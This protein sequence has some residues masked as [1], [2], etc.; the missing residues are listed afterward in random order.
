MG[1]RATWDALADAETR[2][3]VGDP[4]RGAPELAALFGRLG[5]DPRGGVC[6]EVGCGP[7]RMTAELAERFDRVV[8]L[9]ISPAMIERAR[10]SIEATNVEFR[11]ISGLRLDGVDD[12]VADAVVCYLVLQ[13]LPRRRLVESFVRE[14]ARVLKASGE[15][16]VQLPVLERGARPRAWRL[17]RTVSVPLLYRLLPDP[18]RSPA[19]RGVRLT[20]PELARTLARANLKVC[21]RDEGPDAPYRFSRDVFL[22]LARG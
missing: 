9:D 13:H 6:V 2:V 4:T 7:G 8:A 1:M 19:L 22:R 10:G 21:A 20:E 14:F 12:A 11:V 15:A 3:Y 17:A 16:F 5:A 18:V